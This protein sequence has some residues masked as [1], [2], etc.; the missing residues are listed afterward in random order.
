VPATISAAVVIP[1]SRLKLL[2]PIDVLGG[3]LLVLWLVPLLLAISEAPAWGVSSGRLAGLGLVAVAMFSAWLVVESRVSTPL[4]DIDLMRLR[5]VWSTNLIGFLIAVANFGFFLLIPQFVQAPDAS[6]YGFGS[7]VTES[8]IVLLP[9]AVAILIGSA[10]SGRVVDRAGARAVLLV[11]TSL[12][13][14]GPLLF[15]AGH[16]DQWQLYLAGI[17]LGFGF[18][19]SS[20]A[21]ANIIVDTVEPHFT[22][23]ATGMNNVMRMVGGAVGSQLAVSCLNAGRGGD[24]LPAE[25]WYTLAFALLA[26]ALAGAVLASLLVPGKGRLLESVAPVHQA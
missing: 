25:K 1:E 18:G 6:G 8:G 16:S 26:I 15:I 19:W 17:L 2:E 14:S 3:T 12:A 24:G 4:I 13:L 11:G 9:A 7:S 22:G 23:V 20:A 5:G 21:L 10:I